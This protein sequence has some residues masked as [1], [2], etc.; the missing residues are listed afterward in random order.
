MLLPLDKALHDHYNKNVSGLAE[1]IAHLRCNH[2]EED[3]P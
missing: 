2:I 1:T 3:E